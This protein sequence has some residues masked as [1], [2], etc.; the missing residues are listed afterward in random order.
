[1]A[2]RQFRAAGPGKGPAATGWR[3]RSHA[4]TRVKPAAAAAAYAVGELGT[5]PSRPN[6]A[7]VC[8]ITERASVTI[9]PTVEDTTLTAPVDHVAGVFVALGRTRRRQV[10][11]RSVFHLISTKGGRSFRHAFAQPRA[12]GEEDQRTSA[13]LTRKRFAAGT[14]SPGS[15]RI[16][17]DGQ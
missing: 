9:G 4:A 16:R 17:F 3:P 11:V 6:P 2:V 8:Q 5:R 14:R 10:L 1:M 7:T 13:A 15:H 12:Q